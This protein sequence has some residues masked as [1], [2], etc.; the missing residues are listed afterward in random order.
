MTRHS[1]KRGFSLIES[2]IVL[3]VVGLVIGGIWVAAASIHQKMQVNSAEKLV[4][5]VAQ[6]IYNKI[7]LSLTGGVSGWYELNDFVIESGILPKDTPVNV[8]PL[9]PWGKQMLFGFNVNGGVNGGSPYIAIQFTDVPFKICQSL[10]T[11]IPF[12]FKDSSFFLGGGSSSP[13]GSTYPFQPRTDGIYC[14][15]ELQDV[16]FSFNPRP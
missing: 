10:M 15:D 2:A 8:R 6:G 16:G 1:H 14:A 11:T 3:A 4:L 5:M 7:P 13:P 9:D 12:R